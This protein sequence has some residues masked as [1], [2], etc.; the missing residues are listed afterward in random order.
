MPALSASSSRPV[1]NWPERTNVFIGHHSLL[2]FPLRSLGE[3]E[4]PSAERRAVM[5]ARTDASAI[6]RLT[7]TLSARGGGSRTAY[8]TAWCMNFSGGGPPHGPAS[9]SR[10][11]RLGGTL[12]LSTS[13]SAQYSCTRPH[14]SPQ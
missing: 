9:S 6:S 10:L 5:L 2:K 7:P 13:V 12:A 14:G 8:R 11:I 1:N 4:G 3:R